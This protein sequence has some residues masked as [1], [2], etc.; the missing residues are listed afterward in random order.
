[1][2]G[3][4]YTHIQEYMKRTGATAMEPSQ[5]RPKKPTENISN[6]LHF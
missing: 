2:L 3:I 1:M 6:Q 5:E 4:I